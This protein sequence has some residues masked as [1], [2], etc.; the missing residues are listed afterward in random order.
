V[1]ALPNK[2][3]TKLRYDKLNVRFQN[4]RTSSLI[5]EECQFK[6]GQNMIFTV[7]VKGEGVIIKWTS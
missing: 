6:G 3:D 2:L 1:T 5:H 4:N 7:Q